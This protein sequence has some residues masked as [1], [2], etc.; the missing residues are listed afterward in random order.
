MSAATIYIVVKIREG[1]R[2][3]KAV[4]P[5]CPTVAHKL[6]KEKEKRIILVTQDTVYLV[7]IPEVQN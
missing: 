1:S 7:V 4:V 6:Q 5:P 3:A 2:N